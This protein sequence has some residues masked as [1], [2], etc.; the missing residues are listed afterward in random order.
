MKNDGDRDAMQF[1]LAVG[2]AASGAMIGLGY[3]LYRLVA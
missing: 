3:V 2:V 1:L